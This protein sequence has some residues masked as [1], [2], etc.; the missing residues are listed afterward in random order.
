MNINYIYVGDS[1]FVYTDTWRLIGQMGG[2][3][4]K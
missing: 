2:V 4:Y 3:K 1:N